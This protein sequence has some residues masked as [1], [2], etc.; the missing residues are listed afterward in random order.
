MRSFKRLR[1]GMSSSIKFELRSCGTD[2][3]TL[4]LQSKE[5]EEGFRSTKLWSLSW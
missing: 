2:R 5:S 3:N 1:I 4:A